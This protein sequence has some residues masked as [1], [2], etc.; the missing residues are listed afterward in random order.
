MSS[1]ADRQAFVHAS[2]NG[3]HRVFAASAN[4]AIASLVDAQRAHTRAELEADTGVGADGT[5]TM[6]L[7]RLVEAAIVDAT[8]PF[9]VNVLSE[10]VGY[11]DRGSALTLVVDPVDGSA[12][13]AADVPIACFAAALADEHGTF[14]EAATVWLETGRCW[15]GNAAGSVRSPGRW[16]TTGRTMLDG[17]A[18]SLLRPHP[19]NRESW[20]RIVERASRVRILSCTT[21]EA[22]FVLQGSIDAFADAGSDTHRLVDIAAAA[23]LLPTVGGCVVDIY[24]RPVEFTIDLTSRWSAVVAATPQLA[25]AIA[26]AVRGD[27]G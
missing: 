20:W 19:R 6:F 5:S 18:V 8:A 10:E 13:A 12:N 21:I 27:A 14:V 9:G 15:A 16:G 2:T 1:V 4:A 17:A 22:M 7:D 3:L 25:D 24:D 11:I 23:V 26:A